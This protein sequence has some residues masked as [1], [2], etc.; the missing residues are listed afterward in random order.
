MCLSPT[1]EKTRE[2]RSLGA[3]SISKRKRSSTKRV[4]NLDNSDRHG[5]ADVISLSVQDIHGVTIS[6]K[7]GPPSIQTGL[8]HASSPAG[9]A[10][11]SRVARV[12]KQSQCEY[13]FHDLSNT[14][15][16]FGTMGFDASDLPHG[17]PTVIFLA[18]LIQ[19]VVERALCRKL[20]TQQLHA[21]ISIR[22]AA[23]SFSYCGWS[24][25]SASSS[26]FNLM[27]RL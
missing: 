2:C 24:T 12:S 5:Y 25:R 16:P 20:R 3:S 9:A 26:S 17:T 1:C 22:W 18:F 27:I 10:V 23:C 7:F 11:Q 4:G 13:R 8:S 6:K 14:S 15:L 19:P 21:T